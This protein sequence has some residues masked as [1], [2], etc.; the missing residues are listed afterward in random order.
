[1][2]PLSNCRVIQ[3]LTLTF[4]KSSARMEAQLGVLADQQTRQVEVIA[5]MAKSQ[6]K[7]SRKA[8]L[9]RVNSNATLHRESSL[10]RS[11]SNKR[12]RSDHLAPELMFAPRLSLGESQ[13][14]PESI[15][16]LSTISGITDMDLDRCMRPASVLSFSTTTTLTVDDAASTFSA[17]P[18]AFDV[19]SGSSKPTEKQRLLSA[20]LE[21]TLPD[22][23]TSRS[24]PPYDLLSF[25]EF[26]ARK[27]HNVNYIHFW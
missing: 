3:V 16:S 6:Q 5:R 1:M 7:A 24:H 13:N 8:R 18:A 20:R 11:D 21:T 10:A 12:N 17:P 14:R 27:G 9:E 26:V 15:R 23:L 2:I 19:G 22:L 25:S 4:S